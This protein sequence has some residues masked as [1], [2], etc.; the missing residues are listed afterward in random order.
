MTRDAP[1]LLNRMIGKVRLRHLQLVVLT[2][3]LGNTHK[4]A[5]EADISQPSVVKLLGD[6]ERLAETRLF[7]R[8]AR[9]MRPTPACRTLL[10]FLRS[11][12]QVAQTATQSLSDLQSGA[13]GVVHIGAMPAACHGPIMS[14][15]AHFAQAHREIHFHLNEG[16]SAALLEDLATGTVDVLLIRQPSQ[17]PQGCRFVPLLPDRP[18]VLARTGHRLARRRR[19]DLSVLAK[20]QW[21]AFPHSMTGRV[22][23]DSWYK[24]S[25]VRPALVNITT[26]SLSAITTMVAESDALVLLPHTLAGPAL[27]TGQV[28]V[29]DVARQDPI[30]PIGLLWRKETDSIAVQVF[31]EW[32]PRHMAA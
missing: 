28:C 14:A 10:P 21:L 22:L 30:R 23:F 7:E 15:L 18:V 8:H 13:A 11:M 25:P 29:L 19:L 27:A 9:G 6:L 20:E 24:D 16:K 4:V 2:A 12:L 17:T 1:T 32:M 31:C 26:S 5:A 3:D